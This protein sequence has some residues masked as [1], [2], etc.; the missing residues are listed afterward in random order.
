VLTRV[1]LEQHPSCSRFK[2]SLIAEMLKVQLNQSVAVGVST[3]S[4]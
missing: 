2:H 4:A 1:Q 3:G